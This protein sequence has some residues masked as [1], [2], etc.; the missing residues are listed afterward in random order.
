MTL[1]TL[2][3]LLALIWC[4]HSLCLSP[5]RLGACGLSGSATAQPNPASCQ[6]EASPEQ[7]VQAA[8]MLT[9]A[10]S[11]RLSSSMQTSALSQH[12]S[13]SAILKLSSS[14]SLLQSLWMQAR[15]HV[16]VPMD[17][18]EPWHHQAAVGCSVGCQSSSAL[19]HFFISLQ[20]SQADTFPQV[21]YLHG[22]KRMVFGQRFMR[23]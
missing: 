19:G 2:R 18:H 15:P 21:Q 11:C 16:P 12:S 8:E 13:I 14:P 6:P 5:S 17:G 22:E 4:S 10:A 23:R 3:P 1:I 7:S 20:T 9:A